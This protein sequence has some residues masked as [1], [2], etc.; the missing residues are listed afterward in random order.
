MRIRVAT[1]MSSGTVGLN[2]LLRGDRGRRCAAG[3]RTRGNPSETPW[4]L[5]FRDRR[6]Q[7]ET[8]DNDLAI[9]KPG[10]ERP[11]GQD[12]GDA[13]SRTN[14]DQQADVGE[15]GEE[16]RRQGADRLELEGHRGARHQPKRQHPPARG[17]VDRVTTLPFF[18]LSG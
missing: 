11:A 5:A 15:R 1:G 16:Q 4:E 13:R 6:A 2:P 7:R 17:F 3:L 8:A 9:T 14:A 18:G 12:E 10:G